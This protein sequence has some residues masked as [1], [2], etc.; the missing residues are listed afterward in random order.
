[1]TRGRRAEA[2]EQGGCRGGSERSAPATSG[3][4]FFFFFF[5]QGTLNKPGFEAPASPLMHNDSHKRSTLKFFT[6]WIRLWP[7]PS[8]PLISLCE[9]S[10]LA[11]AGLAVL[12]GCGGTGCHASC[13][14]RPHPQGRCPNS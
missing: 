4:D 6:D 3:S 8:Q 7:G 11:G 5:S 13:V 12:L 9:L 10:R 1:M 14:P 2:A